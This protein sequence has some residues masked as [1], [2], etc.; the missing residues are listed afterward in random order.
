MSKRLCATIVLALG[1]LLLA[2]MGTA[3]ASCNLVGLWKGN[4]AWAYFAYDDGSGFG[5]E[6]FTPA[7]GSGDLQVL[8]QYNGLF[9]GDWGGAPVTGNIAGNQIT[10]TS[11]IEGG[12]LI[13]NATVSTDCKTITGTFNYF[14]EGYM[15]TGHFQYTKTRPVSR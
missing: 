7:T 1:L 5:Y 11:F 9:Y 8:N 6:S 10:A 13:I 3:Q 15:D 2:N 14:S 12:V 4:V